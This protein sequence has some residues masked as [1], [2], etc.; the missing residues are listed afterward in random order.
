MGH[1]YLSDYVVEFVDMDKF[2]TLCYERKMT[3]IR[4]RFM[5]KELYDED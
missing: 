1:C 3:L 2:K 4:I 5:G